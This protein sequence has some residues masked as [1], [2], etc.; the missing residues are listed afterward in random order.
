MKVLYALVVF[1]VRGEVY[2]VLSCERDYVLHHVLY[3][4]MSGDRYNMLGVIDIIC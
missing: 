3:Y 4:V 2:Y 1:L